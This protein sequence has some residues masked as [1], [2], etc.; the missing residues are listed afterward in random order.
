M[1][2][3]GRADA[4]RRRLLKPWNFKAYLWLKLPL[5]ACAGLS[6]RQLDEDGRDHEFGE[7]A[8]EEPPQSPREIGGR[9]GRGPRYGA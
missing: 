8:G 5:A 7:P 2:F 4:E 9:A 6:L 3:E 1:I